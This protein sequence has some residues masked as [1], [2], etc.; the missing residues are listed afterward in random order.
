MQ[1]LAYIP[2]VNFPSSE[3]DT[4]TRIINNNLSIFAQFIMPWFSVKH[5]MTLNNFTHKHFVSFFL[6]D[7]LSFHYPWICFFLDIRRLYWIQNFT[8]MLQRRIC[9]VVFV[10]NTRRKRI[11]PM[12]R[13]R[14]PDRTP[15]HVKC[16][17]SRTEFSTFNYF[18]SELCNSSLVLHLS[19]TQITPVPSATRC[20][21]LLF[22]NL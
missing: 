20:A 19:S 14:R 8:K 16:P 13:F 6:L 5:F 9:A 11:N 4:L 2:A 18:G 22:A 1:W 17:V 7:H 12:R 10:E 3:H 21:V 15:M